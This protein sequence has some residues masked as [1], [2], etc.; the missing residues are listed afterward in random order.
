MLHSLLNLDISETGTYPK[1]RTKLHAL[2][3]RHLVSH[4]VFLVLIGHGEGPVDQLV[5]FALLRLHA[6]GHRTTPVLPF[7]DRCQLPVLVSAVGD[8]DHLDVPAPHLRGE[9]LHLLDGGDARTAAR[10]RQC[11]WLVGT[12]IQ[13]APQFLE[14]G[15]EKYPYDHLLTATF[16][17]RRDEDAD[18]DL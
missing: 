15:I 12:T 10:Q 18:D 17:D 5:L 16:G 6:E 4:L 7:D 11:H 14:A 3:S 9:V 1:T 8:G 13:E 2:Q